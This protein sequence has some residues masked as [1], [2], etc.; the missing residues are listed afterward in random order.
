[1]NHKSFPTIT[2]LNHDAIAYMHV[3]HVEIELLE[4]AASHFRCWPQLWIDIDRM[5]GTGA[6]LL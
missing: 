2:S 6:V 3:G 4:I 1:M 5:D